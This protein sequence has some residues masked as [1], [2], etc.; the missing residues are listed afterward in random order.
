MLHAFTLT[1]TLVAA[2]VGLALGSPTS[3]SADDRRLVYAGRF[4][5]RV[6]DPVLSTAL[7]D[8]PCTTIRVAITVSGAGSLMAELDG[9]GSRFLATVTTAAGAVV[10]RTFVNTTSK[11]I[12]NYTLSHFTNDR[13][14]NSSALTVSL[15]KLTEAS[16]F[17]APLSMNQTVAMDHSQWGQ[18]LT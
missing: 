18:K 17:I 16:Y 5:H 10:S 1:L 4:E 11:V 9:G 7:F 3:L 8:W 2:L 6:Y 14:M 12:T 13:G 15:K